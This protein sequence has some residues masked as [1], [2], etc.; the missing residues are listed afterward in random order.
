MKRGNVKCYVVVVV[1]KN[2]LKSVG[3]HGR[4]R[5]LKGFLKYAMT[6]GGMWAW[7]TRNVRR[8]AQWF[9][10]SK[11]GKNMFLKSYFLKFLS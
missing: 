2:I 6:D 9:F 1:L 10:F 8:V 4:Y 5:F 11:K 3:K 7:Q